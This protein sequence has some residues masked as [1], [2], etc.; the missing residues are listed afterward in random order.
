[1]ALGNSETKTAYYNLV[2]WGKPR[3]LWE[4][5]IHWH[6]RKNRMSLIC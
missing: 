5:Q 3:Y 2:A 1:M 6:L 4:T